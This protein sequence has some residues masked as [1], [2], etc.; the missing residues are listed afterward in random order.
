[1]SSE[2]NMVSITIL[3]RMPT[4]SYESVYQ[5]VWVAPFLTQTIEAGHLPGIFLAVSAYLRSVASTQPL[6]SLSTKLNVY[7]DSMLH[8]HFKY[9]YL[10]SICSTLGVVPVS[11][12]IDQLLFD[13]W[14][15]RIYIPRFEHRRDR[16]SRVSSVA[17]GRSACQGLLFDCINPIQNCVRR[18]IVCWKRRVTGN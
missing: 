14:P 12:L 18:S 16:S 6:F 2:L 15:N 9:L 5:L 10:C 7:L 17:R 1:M 11:M 4:D 13:H 3:V 8:L